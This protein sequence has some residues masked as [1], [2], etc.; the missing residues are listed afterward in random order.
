VVLKLEP[1]V[2]CVY[3]SEELSYGI[4]AI[5]LSSAGKAT[6]AGGGNLH[7][8]CIPQSSESSRVAFDN[9]SLKATCPL[10]GWDYDKISISKSPSS[11][12]RLSSIWRD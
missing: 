6:E 11:C 1:L 3:I 4:R 7:M 5:D 12:C 10:V 8:D 2:V 9:R